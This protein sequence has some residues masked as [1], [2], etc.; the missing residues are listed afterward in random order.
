MPRRGQPALP[1]QTEE[2][3]SPRQANVFHQGVLQTSSSR[4]AASAEGWDGLQHTN[5]TSG[6]QMGPGS[7]R[8]RKQLRTRD[9]G[10]RSLSRIPIPSSSTPFPLPYRVLLPPQPLSPE[11]LPGHSRGPE[12][13]P[14]TS[15]AWPCQS[16]HAG[17]FWPLGDAQEA[18]E[19]AERA[20]GAVEAAGSDKP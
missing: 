10:L 11:L 4:L 5:R 18:G 20:G 15:R 14:A 13:P 3:L 19:E 17:P 2:T 7:V 1:G 12:P 8:A 16:R 6:A 9:P